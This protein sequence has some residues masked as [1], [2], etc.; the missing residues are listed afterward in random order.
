MSETNVNPRIDELYSKK[1]IGLLC[2]GLAILASCGVV[3]LVLGATSFGESTL[4]IFKI[5][6]AISAAV[7]LVVLIRCLTCRIC[8]DETGVEVNSPLGGH[9][10][11]RWEEIRTAA[12][13]RITIGTQLTDPLI[14]LSVRE[15][16][17]TLT[18]RALTSRHGLKKH[19]HI[20]IIDSRKRRACVEH[21]LRMTLPEYRL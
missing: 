5:F 6:L 10:R 9:A 14:L 16:E 20:R 19:E 8:I 3:V 1:F 7:Y 12:V 13:V 11:F 2:I 15:P 17:E 21:Y 4:Y 18:N